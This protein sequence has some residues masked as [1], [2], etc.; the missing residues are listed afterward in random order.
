MIFSE[1][2]RIWISS[3]WNPLYSPNK[4]IEGS[5]LDSKPYQQIFHFYITIS[6]AL[7]PHS[8]LS[9]DRVKWLRCAVKL[10][11]HICS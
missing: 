7:G 1:E 10:N 11:D 4:K 5:E 9:S 6:P 8:R 3:Y 2:Y